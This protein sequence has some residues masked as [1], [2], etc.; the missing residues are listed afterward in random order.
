LTVNFV[1]TEYVSTVLNQSRHDRTL[2]D[3]TLCPFVLIHRRLKVTQ[4]KSHAKHNPSC[5]VNTSTVVTMRA[6]ECG[7]REVCIVY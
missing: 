7:S 4:H 1:L 6:S 3:Q 2:D 5:H